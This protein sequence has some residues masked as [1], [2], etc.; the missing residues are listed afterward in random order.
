MP[1]TAQVDAV[2][3]FHS[4]TNIPKEYI[5]PNYYSPCVRTYRQPTKPKKYTIEELKI[6]EQEMQTK[7]LKA[8]QDYA[9]SQQFD[10]SLKVDYSQRGV[11]RR[12][13]EL[14][15]ACDRAISFCRC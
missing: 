15:H 1:R 3:N 4:K 2:D 11:Q 12:V 10:C 13:E 6:Q 14:C 5:K 7:R 9:R 8:E